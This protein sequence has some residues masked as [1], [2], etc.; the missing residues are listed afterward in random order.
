MLKVALLG[1]DGQL[2]SDV[3]ASK[4]A[5]VNLYPL[6]LQDLDICDPAAVRRV[7]NYLKPHIVL[8]ATGYVKVDEAE[9]EVEE[10]FRVN[11]FAPRTIARTCNDIDAALMH[12]STDYVFDGR[13][14]DGIPYDEHDCAAPLNAYGLSKYTGELFI[15]GIM[16]HHYI[17][18]T[19][20]IY[21]RAGARGK[22]GNF[23][24]AILRKAKDGENLKVIKD[25]VMSPTST[26]DLSLHLWTMLLECYD[27]GTYHAVNEGFCSWH[28]FACAIVELAGLAAD[29]EPIM[30]TEFAAKARRPLWS[31]LRSS[32]GIR[33][34][35]WR[36][37]LGDFV[38]T[39]A[40]PQ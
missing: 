26:A 5:Q 23:I 6:T 15:R 17:V 24:T 7:L 1:A 33:L 39:L 9:D 14:D 4:P 12:I 13:R 29:I 32:R 35:G 31:P 37:A 36:E 25:M 20:G 2:G 28:E 38:R 18:R 16:D 40:P 30:H 3:A 10:A 27:Y 11:A 34:R 19:A 22:G 21:G 8:N